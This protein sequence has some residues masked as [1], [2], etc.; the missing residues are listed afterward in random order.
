MINLKWILLGRGIQ[1]PASGGTDVTFGTFEE[2]SE[3]GFPIR[4]EADAG[5]VNQIKGLRRKCLNR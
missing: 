3:P 5:Q 2:L 1:F 4:R